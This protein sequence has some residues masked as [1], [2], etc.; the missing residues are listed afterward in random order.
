MN[1]LPG[2]CAGD[3][4]ELRFDNLADKII[5]VLLLHNVEKLRMNQHNF[6]FFPFKAYKNILKSLEHI[7]SQNIEDIDYQ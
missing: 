1:I 7:H 5:H 4:E 2:R 3:W 6:E